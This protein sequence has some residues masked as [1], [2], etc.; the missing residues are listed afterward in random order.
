MADPTD[1]GGSF[2]KKSDQRWIRIITPEGSPEEV[3]TARRSYQRDREGTLDCLNVAGVSPIANQ[4]YWRDILTT[5]FPSASLIFY[6]DM[7]YCDPHYAYLSK[8]RGKKTASLIPSLYLGLDAD[9][10]AYERLSQSYHTNQGLR[11]MDRQ[12]QQIFIPKDGLD[13]QNHKGEK[14][15]SLSRLLKPLFPL[16]WNKQTPPP[17]HAQLKKSFQRI[18]PRERFLKEYFPSFLKRFEAGELEGEE[19]FQE[20]P[21]PDDPPSA[22]RLEKMGEWRDSITGGIEQIL[23]RRNHVSFPEG[24]VL[25]MFRYEESVHLRTAVWA[26][27]HSLEGKQRSAGVFFDPT[28]LPHLEQFLAGQGFSVVMDGNKEDVSWYTAFTIPQMNNGLGRSSK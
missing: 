14:R 4:S 24:S 10:A 17:M 22:E 1:A 7:R 11:F 9:V 15:N 6:P 16:F 25:E 26:S 12:V 18:Y 20:N 19:F 5:L 21:N 27:F 3:Q 23:G 8:V 13:A 28:R 2:P